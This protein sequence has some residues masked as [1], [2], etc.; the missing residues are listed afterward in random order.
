MDKVPVTTILGA[1]V[2][3]TG[4]A[5]VG[6]IGYRIV[7]TVSKIGTGENVKAAAGTVWSARPKLIFKGLNEPIIDEIEGLGGIV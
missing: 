2:A 1:G 4:V 6:Y 5:I 3:I 7:K